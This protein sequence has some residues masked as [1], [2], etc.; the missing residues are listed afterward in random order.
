MKEVLTLYGL[1]YFT[2]AQKKL[3]YA[4]D[5][6]ADITYFLEKYKNIL[7]FEM[8]NEHSFHFQHA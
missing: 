6:I 1:I 8:V 2:R 5:M 4:I 3:K 7:V